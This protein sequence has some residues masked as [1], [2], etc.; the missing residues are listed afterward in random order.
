MAIGYLYPSLPPSV[1][2][3]K[4]VNYYKRLMV[5]QAADTLRA[6]GKVAVHRNYLT[7]K[8]RQ[9]LSDRRIR[10]GSKTY[11]V[12]QLAEVP[13]RAKRAIGDSPIIEYGGD[14]S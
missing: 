3:R 13:R 7:Q 6:A 14:F 11:Y 1:I 5:A 12:M 9:E 2:L 8:R 10:I 4:T